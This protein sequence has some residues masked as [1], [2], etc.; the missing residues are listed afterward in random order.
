MSE[1]AASSF[2]IRASRF[3][4][5]FGL[6]L[7]AKEL[8]EQAARPRTYKLRV[9][10]ALLLYF[11]AFLC[12][13]GTFGSVTA[14]PLA[15]LG[16]GRGMFMACIDLQLVGI[17]LFMP[18]I[19][20]GAIT[21]EKERG[22]LPLLFLTRL[23]PW[24]ILFEKLLGRVIPMLAFVLLSLPMLAIAYTMGGIS[25]QL[26]W[27]GVLL[28]VL[29]TIQMGTL[30]LAC[31]AFF[32]TTVGAFMASYAIAFL[33]FF[34]PYFAWLL[35]WSVVH[36]A[37]YDMFEPLNRVVGDLGPAAFVLGAFPFMGF[38]LAFINSFSTA[39]PGGIGNWAMA[40]HALIILSFSAG[41]LAVA[42]HS[43][44]RRASLPPRN[45]LLEVLRAFDRKP[46]AAPVAAP[47]GSGIETAQGPAASGVDESLLPADE[48]IAWRETTKRSFGRSRYFIRLLLFVEV[49]LI[50]FCLLLVFS[51][52][53]G[54]IIAFSLLNIVAWGLAV[55]VI[56]V[57]AAS[58][59]TGER[60]RQTLD[61][62]CTSPLTG[63]EII[64]QKFRGVQHLIMLAVVPIL[65]IAGFESYFKSH[66]NPSWW[67]T[68]YDPAPHLFGT[69]L[70]VAV[71]LPMV[72]WLAVAIGMKIHSQNRA[73][74]GAVGA[75]V[76][77]CVLPVI[78]IAVP[79]MI[80]GRAGGGSGSGDPL[81]YV[82][83]LS[84]AMAVIL[85]EA[86]E[87]REVA[88]GPF[89]ALLLNFGVYAGITLFLRGMCL[90][91]ADRMLGRLESPPSSPMPTGQAPAAATHL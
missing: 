66:F 75:I 40:A 72:A 31:S 26:M 35:L 79:V 57:Q 89:V 86:D 20:C 25:Q 28:L 10:Y 60:S 2:A 19:T 82:F 52:S 24:A 58:L 53:F 55:L 42:R 54:A 48:P 41:C 65:T 83:L 14:S 32:R 81:I 22:S 62:L 78:F 47:P 91:H 59:I 3:L 67:S 21:N 51:D 12:F 71:Y 33:L 44:I 27:H 88:G 69:V 77:W 36:F 6:P 23:G 87:L 34:G 85:N 43:L 56:A 49:P 64:R 50:A 16:H 70:A 74:I 90:R 73:M 11:G 76:G 18:A 7:L 17:Y 63:R 45:L 1:I 8:T 46:R 4:R 5:T 68:R 13:L 29:A 84:P 38:A 9:G 39:L 61:V 15:I 37:G 80:V 30:A